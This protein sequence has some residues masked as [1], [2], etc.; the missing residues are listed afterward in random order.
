[1][2]PVALAIV[3]AVMV[4]TPLKSFRRFPALTDRWFH[5]IA[6]LRASHL[7]RGAVLILSPED[8]FQYYRDADDIAPMTTYF[9]QIDDGRTMDEIL[10]DDKFER[11]ALDALRGRWPDAR[12]RLG[13][14]QGTTLDGRFRVYA[15]SCVAGVRP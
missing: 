15:F 14:C 8:W 12:Q 10:V 6:E 7:S 5:A 2:A 13:D 11:Q 9:H 4:S 3:M 1:V